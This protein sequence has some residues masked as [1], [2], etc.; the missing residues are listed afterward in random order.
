MDCQNSI[1]D[2]LVSCEDAIK[3]YALL[4][5]AT[6][7]NWVITD[8]FGKQYSG[9]ALTD[10][11][12]FPSI[13]VDDLPPGLLTPFSGEF[14]LRF[15]D[16]DTCKWVDFKA[17]KVYDEIRFE[18]KGGSRVK[19]ELLCSFEC[20]TDGSGNSAVFTFTDEA[21]VDIPWTSLLNSLYGNSPTVQVYHET[22]PDT[23]ELA[24]VAITLDQTGYTLNSINVDNGGP[25]TG[26]VLINS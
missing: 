20:S 12:G 19:D 15:Q 1:Y 16:A 11:N 7:Y 8:K 21:I 2:Y 18:V 17:A 22:S 6:T 5:P 23:F 14:S 4:Q 24:S 3:I 25:A 10:A 13:A 26:Y 9:L